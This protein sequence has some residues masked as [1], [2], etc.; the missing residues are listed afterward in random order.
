MIMFTVSELNRYIAFQLKGE[1]R[2]E[3]NQIDT[4]HFFLLFLIDR[5]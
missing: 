4:K 2:Q 5:T 3:D 1:Y